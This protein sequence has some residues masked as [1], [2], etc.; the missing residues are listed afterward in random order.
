V[1]VVQFEGRN[2]IDLAN[3]WERDL[4]IFLEEEALITQEDHKRI[5]SESYYKRNHVNIFNVNRPLLNLSSYSALD[6]SI[7][8]SQTLH[9]IR[10]L[11]HA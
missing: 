10:A 2:K 7:P 5:I 3:Y 1:A 4:M 11:D 9:K 6:T 8:Q